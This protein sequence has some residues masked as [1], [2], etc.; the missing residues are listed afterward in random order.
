LQK[1]SKLSLEELEWVSGVFPTAIKSQ[2]IRSLKSFREAIMWEALA[3]EKPERQ[4]Q[5]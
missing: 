4:G 3:T 1:I 2:K 5:P